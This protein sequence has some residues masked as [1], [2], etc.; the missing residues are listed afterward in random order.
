MKSNIS[1][2]IVSVLILSFLSCNYNAKKEKSIEN[3]VDS[4]S[5]TGKFAVQGSREKDLWQTTSDQDGMTPKNSN[6]DF[7]DSLA[8]HM[9][10]LNKQVKEEFNKVCDLYN[11]RNVQI[12]KLIKIVA[13][14][15]MAVAIDTKEIN[16][17]LNEF[18]SFSIND[19]LLI[20]EIKFNSLFSLLENI[21]KETSNL[22]FIIYKNELKSGTF[23]NIEKELSKI[24]S[25]II[26]H[27]NRY[28][29]LASSYNIKVKAEG[30][31]YFLD[32][33]PELGLMPIIKIVAD[34]Q[35]APIVEF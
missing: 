1:I 10:K 28:N 34:V 5:D 27:K 11:L 31:K 30:N 20:D 16:V 9:C 19:E 6:E 25:E 3:I 32:K 26:Y 17:Y 21:S 2:L 24:E 8:L 29:A 22:V 13:N 4:N 12:D 33:Y 35:K 23:N 15:P 18:R 7:A 14:S